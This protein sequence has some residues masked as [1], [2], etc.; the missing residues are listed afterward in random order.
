[1]CECSSA[2]DGPAGVLHGL[3]HRGRRVMADVARGLAYLHE[4]PK[5][6]IHLDVKSPNVLLTRCVSPSCDTLLWW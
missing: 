5:E 2:T 4:P 6:I 1:M 3:P